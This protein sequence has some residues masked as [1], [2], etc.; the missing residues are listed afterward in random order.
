V[1]KA[2]L[3]IQNLKTYYYLDEGVLK[4][5]DGVSLKMGEMQTLGVIGERGCGKSVTAQSVLRIVPK[6]GKTVAGKIM[7]RSR[8]SESALDLTQMNPNSDEIL[9]VSIQAQILNLL[10]DLQKQF[11]LTYL[12]WEE[13]APEHFAACHFA[14]ELFL[15]GV[16]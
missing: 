15:N 8:N 14:T 13:V 9:D 1:D 11:H 3:E 4:A 2:V 10:Q 6:P 7:L 12:F 16:E 5:V